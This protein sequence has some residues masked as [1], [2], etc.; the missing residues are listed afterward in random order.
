MAAKVKKITVWDMPVRFCHW[1]I[2]ALIIALYI[3]AKS[4]NMEM[5][6]LWGKLLLT[7][8]FYRMCWGFIGSETAL[9]EK[10]LCNPF[11]L[12][13]YLRGKLMAPRYGH[14]PLGGW[15][16]M[17]MLAVLAVQAILGLCSRDDV[18]FEGPIVK[19][20]GEHISNR[21]THL[22]KLDFYFVLLPLI[23]LHIGAV[24]YYYYVKK[25]D[26]ISPMITGE[27]PALA[28]GDEDPKPAQAGRAVTF[29]M[30]AFTFWICLNRL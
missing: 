24:L 8:I 7:L 18:L 10:F 17:A 3:T 15:S 20:L 16:I 4:G 22:H 13:A 30:G 23:A 28:P 14:N 5:H 27:T 9:F 26:L 2:V 12:W 1:G 29:A 6:A 25:R 19:Y 21:I 11:E